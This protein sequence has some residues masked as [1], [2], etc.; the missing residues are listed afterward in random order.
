MRSAATSCGPARATMAADQ[1]LQPK[2]DRPHLHG[3]SRRS[4]VPRRPRQFGARAGRPADARGPGPEGAAGGGRDLRR[5]EDL[6]RAQRHLVIEQDRAVRLYS[7]RATS[8]CSTATT[9][10]PP[11][12]ARS[13]SAAAFRSSWSIDRNACCGLIGLIFH[14]ADST[15]R[16][17]ATRSATTDLL[18]VGQ[19]GA[20][21]RERCS[22]PASPVIEQC[23]YDGTIY[24]IAPAID[25]CRG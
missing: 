9:T 6:L 2:P 25:R 4:G 15:R 16:A 3:A 12:T 1:S 11:I 23:T 20:R 7:W 5:R 22:I 13:S 17:S 10:R 21:R 19:W 8:C 14:E 24:M 18:V